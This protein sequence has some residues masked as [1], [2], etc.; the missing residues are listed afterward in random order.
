[1]KNYKILFI[2]VALI[3]F[4]GF[5]TPI[6]AEKRLYNCTYKSSTEDIKIEFTLRIKN[7]SI[8]AK[9]AKFSGKDQNDK[10]GESVNNWSNSFFK[11]LDFKGADYYDKNKKCPPYAVL[12]DSRGGYNLFVSDESNLEAIKNGIKDKYKSLKENFPKVLNLIIEE[13]KEVVDKPTSCLDFNKEPNPNAEVG[14][15]EFYSC[16]KNPYFACIWNENEDY[17][18]YCNVDKLQ[19]V[20][21]GEAFDIPHQVPELISFLVNFLKIVTPIILIFV[22]IITLFKAIVASKEDEIKKAQSS[23]IKKIIAAVMVFFVISIVQFVIMKVADSTDQGGLD[24][25]L[26]CFLNNDCEETYYK[27]NVGGK[28]ICT[29]LN[30]TDAECGD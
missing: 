10:L 17:G 3:A 25:C 12:S 2:V 23:L 13:E 24:S 27:T 18:G 5:V 6:R 14:T 28:N 7:K 1:M 9:K 16:E 15:A 19:Y 11:N 20:K 22:S 8:I 4:L 26:S 30:G 21:C 29:Y